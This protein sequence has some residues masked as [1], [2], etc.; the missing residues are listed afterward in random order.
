VSQIKLNV[1][2][3]GKRGATIS[4]KR[5]RQRKFR[6]SAVGGEGIRVVEMGAAKA[7]NRGNVRLLE[8]KRGTQ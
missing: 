4:K 1:R 6:T 8:K 3:R 2:A 7:G 5:V